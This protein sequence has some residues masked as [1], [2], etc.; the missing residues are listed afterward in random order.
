MILQFLEGEHMIGAEE[1]A[2]L[3][4]EDGSSIDSEQQAEIFKNIERVARKDGS[5][6]DKEQGDFLDAPYKLSLDDGSRIEPDGGTVEVE[7]VAPPS[8]DLTGGGSVQESL[9]DARSI[10]ERAVDLYNRAND[11]PVEMRQASIVPGMAGD[12]L[13]ESAGEEFYTRRLLNSRVTDKNL[14]D[15]AWKHSSEPLKDRIAQHNRVLVDDNGRPMVFPIYGTA[16]LQL[17]G[18]PRKQLDQEL[19]D[20]LSELE[21]EEVK[22]H[23]ENQ[24]LPTALETALG[25]E[26]YEDL[27]GEMDNWIGRL[28]GNGEG[29]A[30]TGLTDFV[31]ADFYGSP[32]IENGEL[33]DRSVRHQTYRH[34]L[35]DEEAEAFDE[36]VVG[37]NPRIRDVDSSEGF[38]RFLEGFYAEFGP[39]KSAGE[40]GIAEEIGLEEDESVTVAVPAEAT[41]SYEDLEGETEVMVMYDGGGGIEETRAEIP[42]EELPVPV[43]NFWMDPRLRPSARGALELRTLPNIE[44]D[45]D[46]VKDT[47]TAE[48]FEE[49]YGEDHA[50]EL[51]D[52]WR[53]DMIY[54]ADAFLAEL[55]RIQREFADNGIEEIP[56]RDSRE[57]SRTLAAEGSKGFQYKNVDR[58]ELMYSDGGIVD[59]ASDYLERERDIDGDAFAQR[60]KMRAGFN[61]DGNDMSWRPTPAHLQADIYRSRYGDAA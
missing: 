8:E 56:C 33:V 9:K 36:P 14:D 7:M 21:P 18:T 43:D 28:H 45:Y 11:K 40:L 6:R 4:E 30:F 44:F 19:R 42:A 22:K 46:E 5:Y 48:A 34:G 49:A 39:E 38:Y 2:L 59:L 55:P 32:Q 16:S 13:A 26:I 51:I 61:P 15:K 60:V 12:E 27:M 29:P 1:E 24:D 23:A 50:R 58:D 53:Q 10:V 41:D 20:I 25:E 54:M 47:A 35:N 3:L 57:M 17:T 31:L 37:D 52:S